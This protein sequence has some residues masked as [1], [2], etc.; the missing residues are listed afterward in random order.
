MV[1]LAMLLFLR[2]QHCSRVLAVYVAHWH[3]GQMGADE[4]HEA[5]IHC[6][7]YRVAYGLPKS[8]SQVLATVPE[9]PVDHMVSYYCQHCDCATHCHSVRYCDV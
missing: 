6:S 9:L 4:I 7:R 5:I 8:A 3:G 1:Q 2:Y